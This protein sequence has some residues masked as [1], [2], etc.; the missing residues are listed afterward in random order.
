MKV[1]FSI[2][3]KITL[4]AILVAG[5]VTVSVTYTNVTKFENIILE[6]NYD[7]AS[8]LIQALDAS[9]GTHERLDDQDHLSR[10]IDNFIENNTYEDK[11]TGEIRERILKVNINLLD[12]QGNL[13]INASSDNTTIG[14]PANSYVVEGV[15][16]TN[17][18]YEEDNT[19]YIPDT[20]R[21]VQILIVLSPVNK[22]GV[23]LGTYEIIISMDD[24][25]TT[26]NQAI[27]DVIGYSTIILLIMLF[28]FLFLLRRSIVK[29][30]IQFR[31]T[32]EII[33]KGNLDAKI[34]IKSRDELGELAS[35]FNKMAEDLKESRSKIEDYNKI[36][37]NLLD[38]KDEFIGQLGHDLKNPLQPLVGLLPM[39]I[40]QEK[41]PKIKEALDIMNK[42]A[43]YMKDLIFDTLQLA[44]LRSETIEFDIQ[45]QNLKEIAEEVI[46]TQKLL[47]EENKIEIDS[48]IDK[49]IIVQADKL[50]L[51][52]V[53]KNLITN[54]IKY[55]PDSSGKIIIDAKK[56]KDIITVSVKDTGIGMTKEQKSHIFDEFYKA[57][58]FSS[59]YGSTGLGLAIVKRIVEKH[60]GKI[61]V[62]SDGPGKGSTFYFTLKSKAK[63]N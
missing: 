58:K 62:E 25:Y 4:I 28:V 22:S 54:S 7:K 42:N 63:N 12:A 2:S 53:F 46:D 15:D 44:K 20:D 17:L 6:S 43:I 47:L 41:D 33:G 16:Y 39:L 56:E 34:E 10:V 51:V 50:R 55:T 38:R 57:D 29:P 26:I 52:E 11:E 13:L 21:E 30:V 35:A 32:A 31:D 8:P 45:D 60:D 48:K 37:E 23:I 59:E 3:L 27:W 40:E 14:E 18:C 36:L 5:I 1:N 49:D 19:Y 24:A 61:W 9:V